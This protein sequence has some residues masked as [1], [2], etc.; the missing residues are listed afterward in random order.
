MKMT[1]DYIGAPA[2]GVYM[3]GEKALAILR[4]LYTSSILNCSDLFSSHLM[5]LEGEP[6][7]RSVVRDWAYSWSVVPSVNATGEC[8]LRAA[9]WQYAQPEAEAGHVVKRVRERLIRDLKSLL[10]MMEEVLNC[11]FSMKDVKRSWKTCGAGERKFVFPA[12]GGDVVTTLADVKCF[13]YLVEKKG[14]STAA[15]AGMYGAER[16]AELKGK[17]ASVIEAEAGK[18]ARQMVVEASLKGFEAFMARQDVEPAIA[19]I[20][21]A[22]EA[23][24]KVTG[25]D[26]ASEQFKQELER[27]VCHIRR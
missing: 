13:L 21:K 4:A 24:A 10:E 6:K 26:P 18:L 19:A 8:E 16:I 20:E 1:F 14:V 5:K 23:A 12:E 27:A 17:P 2:C 15:G 7:W 11:E 3:H 9:G 22:L 25:V